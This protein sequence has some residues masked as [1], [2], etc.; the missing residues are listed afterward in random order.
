M[1]LFLIDGIGPFFGDY[2]K[3]RINWSK[4]PFEHLELDDPEKRAKRFIRIR[5]DMQTFTHCAAAMGFNAITLDDVAHLADHPD[6]EP[7]IRARI[8]AYRS[9]S[10]A[11]FKIIQASGLKIYITMDILSMSAAIREQVGGHLDRAITFAQELLTHLFADFPQIAGIIMRIGESDGQD[12]KGPLRSELLL[13][14]P[15]D[16]NRFIKALLPTFE[17]EERTLIFRTWTVGAYSIGD[18]MWHR[19]TFTRTLKGI[20]S[21]NF[22]VSMKF[23]ESDFFRHLPLNSNFFRTTHRKII[24][25]QTRH[26]Y[27]GAGEYP[28][29]IG[30]DYSQYAA[31]LKQAPNMVGIIIWC[32]TGGWHPFRRRTLIDD[33]AVWAGINTH[34]ALGIFK[35]GLSPD[36]ALMQWTGRER[37]PEINE[38]LQLSEEVIK[39]LL[40]EPQFAQQKLFFRRVRIPPLLAVFWNTLFINHAARR[41]LQHYVKDPQQSIDQATVAMQ[42][43]T[44]MQ[45]L[46][47][48]SGLPAD[49]IE[50]MHDTLNL[51]RL[52]RRYFLLPKDDEFESELRTTRAAYKKKYPKSLRPR[53]R[54]KLDLGTSEFSPRTLSLGLKIF[55]RQQRGYRLVDRLILLRLLAIGYWLVRR[56]APKMIP[57]FARKS[58]MGVDA[59]FR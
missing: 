53:Y 47:E 55:L 42:K 22:I 38:L 48:Q 50:F 3:R 52:A 6:Y 44:R 28:S 58:A 8:Q 57:K 11:L 16:T 23:G 19:D 34:V 24:E 35:D 25:L 4:I 56:A 33:N 39:K 32:Q 41:V 59:V 27:E 7:A 13:R 36:A 26:E 14:T 21:A 46:A 2:K 18:L 54:I 17:D 10:I 30:Q 29:Y 5:E 12:V 49:D 40:Y 1:E 43:L 20:D 31:Q 37:F 15:H 9:E 45:Q 51:V